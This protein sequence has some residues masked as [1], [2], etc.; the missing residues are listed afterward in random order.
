[1]FRR[2]HPPSSPR[3]ITAK[4]AGICPETAKPIAIGDTIAWY[5]A[6]GRAFHIDSRAACDLRAQQFASTWQMLDINH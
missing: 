1:M 2:R 6:T 4:Q 3:F 5:P